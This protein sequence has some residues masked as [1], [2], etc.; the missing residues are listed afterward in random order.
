MVI[1][2]KSVPKFIELAKV[3]DF[4]GKTIHDVGCG[5]GEF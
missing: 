4:S 3:G 2:T 5:N 1:K